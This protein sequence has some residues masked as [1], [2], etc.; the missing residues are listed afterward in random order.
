MEIQALGYLGIGTGKLDDWSDFATGWLGMQA[1]D[2]GAGVRAFRMDDR[3]QRLVVDRALPEGERYFGWEVADAAALDALAARLERAG[4]A[5]RREPAALADQRFV[6]GLISFADPAGNRLEAFHG[7]Q[8]A[9]E[10]FR[11]GR[12]IAGFRTG[13]CGMGH[14]LLMVP[15]I[16][17]ALAFYRDLLGFRISDFIRQPITAYFLHVNPRHHSVAL[18]EAPH[19]GMHHLM[20]ELYSFDDVGQ[21]Y[22]IAVGHRERIAA[23]LGRHPNDLITSFYLRSPSD[24]LI[25]YGWGGREVD[26]ATWQPQEMTT[27]GSFWGHDGLFNSLGDDGPPPPPFPLA[28]PEARRAPLQVIDGNYQRMSGVCPW[29]DSVGGRG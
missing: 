13:P 28:P 16:D 15:C 6:R 11:P 14:A 9:D 21:G 17:A 29:W 25:E 18:V 2:R 19:S 5:V 27:I 23:T 12:A 1:V 4:V 3:K 24:I 20:V 7:A 8:I 26:D 22:D 10:P